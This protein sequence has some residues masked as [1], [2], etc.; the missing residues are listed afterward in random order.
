MSLAAGRQSE[1]TRG[2]QVSWRVRQL[3]DEDVL[4]DVAR[5]SSDRWQPNAE[6]Q[7]GACSRGYGGWFPSEPQR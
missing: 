6:V 2:V 4:E 1:L 7:Q 5:I 3:Y